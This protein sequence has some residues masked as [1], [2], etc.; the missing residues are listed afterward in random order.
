[1]SDKRIM[2][3]LR[4]LVVALCGC[5]MQLMEFNDQEAETAGNFA[6]THWSLVLAAGESGDAKKEPKS[7][8]DER[9]NGPDEPFATP[10]AAAGLN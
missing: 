5:T 6:T 8:R 4:V 7:A 3:F 2:S 9:A 1:M 10:A